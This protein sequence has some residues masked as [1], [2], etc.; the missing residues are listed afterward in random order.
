MCGTAAHL[1]DRV[2]P[3]VPLRQ[4]VLSVPFELRLL[5][6]KRAQALSAVGRIFVQESGAQARV[7][8]ARLLALPAQDA[9]HRHHTSGTPTTPKPPNSTGAHQTNPGS[10]PHGTNPCDAHTASMAW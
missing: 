6:A 8:G 3:D 2:L 9:N 1:T 7:Q 5:L 4:W 10:A